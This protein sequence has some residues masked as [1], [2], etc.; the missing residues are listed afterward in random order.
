[1]VHLDNYW[2]DSTGTLVETFLDGLH[3][4]FL[5]FVGCRMISGLTKLL[6]M[7]EWHGSLRAITGT[8]HICFER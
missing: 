6:M 5:W 8:R 7:S 1:M 3:F 2:V 4:D